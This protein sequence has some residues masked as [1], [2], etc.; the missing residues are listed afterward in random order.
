MPDIGVK[1]LP[2]DSRPQSPQLFISIAE[3]PDI[4]EQKQVV[5]AVSYLNS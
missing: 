3:G 1:K 4:L 5:S 2:D